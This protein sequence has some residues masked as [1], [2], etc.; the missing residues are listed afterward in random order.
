[1]SVAGLTAIAAGL[2]PGTCR[3]WMLVHPVVVEALQVRSSRTVTVPVVR[4]P[5]L[6]T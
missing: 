3:V 5:E 4:E 2:P 1:V 6:A